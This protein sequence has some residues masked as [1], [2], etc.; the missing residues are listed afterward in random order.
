MIYLLMRCR[1]HVIFYF[2]FG[3]LASEFYIFVT[4]N[5]KKTAQGLYLTLNAHCLLSTSQE[6]VT[7]ETYFVKAFKKFFID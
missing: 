3:Q 7:L 6:R 4:L 2:Y 5:T 1:C